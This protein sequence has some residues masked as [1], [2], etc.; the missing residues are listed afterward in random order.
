VSGKC[1]VV[2]ERAVGM[3][4][5]IIFFVL[6][7]GLRRCCQRMVLASVLMNRERGF[8]IG[9]CP[10]ILV[11]AG[12]YRLPSPSAYLLAVHTEPCISIR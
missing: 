3:D 7:R 1:F 5:K 4:R 6:F 11:L 10:M 8:L 2:S 12:V 9:S